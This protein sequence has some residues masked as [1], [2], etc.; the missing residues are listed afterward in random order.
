MKVIKV[1]EFTYPTYVGGIE[2]CLHQLCPALAR[3]G[4]NVTLLTCA[5]KGLPRKQFIEGFEVRRVDFLGVIGAL[6]SRLK[7]SGALYGLI[8]RTLFLIILPIHLIKALGETGAEA[9]HVHCLCALSA[10]PASITKMLTGKPLIITMHGTFL[11]YYS[12]AIKP[13]LSWLISTAEKAYLRLGV[14]DKILVEDKYTYKLLIKLGISRE[15]ISLL[16]YPGIKIEV[17]RKAHPINALKDK[18]II[19]HHGRLVPKRGL[20]NLIEAMPKVIGGFPEATLIIA[21]EGPEKT[22]LRKLAE[23][24][25]L[26]QHVRFIGL[27]PY[28]L[29]P[30]LVKSSTIVVNPSLVEGHSS[31]VIEA[32]AA[33]K[34]VIA[35]K[36]GGITDIIR[37]GE[38]GILIEPENPDQIAEAIMK[39][40]KNPKMME[41]IG[42]RASKKAEEFSI[43][44]LAKKEAQIY[45]E[46]SRR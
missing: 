42:E 3:L 33:S 18:L 26:A 1:R 25:G 8:A 17:F 35:T 44:N 11:G 20:K 21:G 13:P 30:A 39:L 22:R 43:E 29:I 46:F 15:K 36:V 27:A 2:T 4:V 45:Q 40:L 34:P 37:D 32:M 5:E 9:I 28:E 7:V 19:L 10:L 41:A 6:T 12:K 31:S 16:P 14:Y 23:N 24:L 38:T